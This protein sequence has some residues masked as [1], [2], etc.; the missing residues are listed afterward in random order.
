MHKFMIIG[1]SLLGTLAL[2][3]VLGV[4]TPPA[5]A[6][7]SANCENPVLIDHY[8]GPVGC[9]SCG[10]GRLYYYYEETWE[11]SCSNGGT[12]TVKELYESPCDQCPW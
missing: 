8:I 12:C 6:Q 9:A 3:L 5:F 7:C 1:R 2:V 10:W 4:G 11:Y